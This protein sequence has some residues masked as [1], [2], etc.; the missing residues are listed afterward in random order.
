M[1][2]PEEKTATDLPEEGAQAGQQPAEG[3]ESQEAEELPSAR[4][5]KT[6]RDKYPDMDWDNDPEAPYKAMDSHNTELNGKLDR[7]S[8]SQKTINDVLLK[9]PKFAMALHEAAGGAN[10]SLA[11]VKHYGKEA[12]MSADDP[13][14]AEE[15][16]KANQ[17]YLDNMAKS[18]K[19]EEQQMAN[20]E[21][22][23]AN[24]E[25]LASEY[26]L[27]EEQSDQFAEMLFQLADDILM[28]KL[29]KE[30]LTREWLGMNHEQ[31][32]LESYGRG[33]NDGASKKIRTESKNSLGD[34]VPSIKSAAGAPK[35]TGYKKRDVFGPEFGGQV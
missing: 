24:M 19:I 4:W 27:T 22:S 32:I 20:M 12:L 34:G 31:D 8:Q 9:D 21:E 28:G 11:L 30:M 17:E 1:T 14:L 35:P 3:V 29:S 26:E 16:V 15:F 18:K 5:G 25:A 7:Y 13:E 6:M 2:D 10:P 33:I 23:I